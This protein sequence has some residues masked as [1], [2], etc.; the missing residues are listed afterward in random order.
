MELH[1][2]SMDDLYGKS[3]HPRVGETHSKKS[4]VFGETNGGTSRGTFLYPIWPYP[5]TVNQVHLVVELAYEF[6]R[7]SRLATTN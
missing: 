4:A 7:G 5:Y 2:E 6:F 1:K 3:Q